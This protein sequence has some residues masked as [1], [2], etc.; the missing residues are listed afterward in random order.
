[1]NTAHPRRAAALFLIALAGCTVGPDH[2]AP[3]SEA[4]GDWPEPLG[5][6][7][8]GAA[9]PAELATWWSAFEDDA[10]DRLIARALEGSLDIR[11]AAARVREARALRGVAHA[12]TLPEVDVRAGAS[13]ERYSENSSGNFSGGDEEEF[14]DAGFD[15]SWELDV[16]GGLRRS[17]EAADATLQSE[18]E[19]ARQVR[20]TLVAEV[21]RNYTELRSFQERLALARD[22]V[23]IQE[24]TV[25]VSR[26]RVESGVAGELELAQANAQYE[27]S[28]SQLPVLAR[29]VRESAYRLDVLLG[30][31]PGTLI[32]ELSDAK[33]IPVTP[34][35]VAVG[36]P[37]E[38]VRRR[39]DIRAAE[40]EL[41]AATARIGV[42]TADLYPRF[43]LNGAF[44][45]ES[46][47]FGDL[48][49]SGSRAW[50]LGPAEVRWPIF[51]AGRVRNAIRVEEARQELAVVAYERSVL[52]A[53]EEVANALLGYARLREQRESLQRAVDASANSVE[54]ANELWT[55]GLTDFLNVLQ[56]QEDLFQLEDRLATLEADVT[57]NTITLYKALGGGWDATGDH[58]VATS[59]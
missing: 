47:N 51:D 11:E 24:E 29:G 1:V 55:R 8:S 48:F 3:S 49:D 37:A 19:T 58:A 42:A 14:Y 43:T 28:R 52:E 25:E 20:V 6:G 13:V 40:R 18:I 23:R 26:S 50:S 2:V 22:N 7:L 30:R 54:L 10:L 15:A 46:D 38:L 9:D 57:L 56:T 4:P 31:R 35:L 59:E 34:D 45:F 16:F 41:A 53:Y 21:A 17:V 5:A 33:A 36:L 39:P 27:S 12:E 32:A 44:G